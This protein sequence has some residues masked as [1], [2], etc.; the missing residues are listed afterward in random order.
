MTKFDTGWTV[1]GG[2]DGMSSALLAGRLQQALDFLTNY[3]RVPV[4]SGR[5]REAL[6]V[7]KS[8]FEKMET[9]RVL[10]AFRLAWETFL[11]VVAAME[12]AKNPRTPFTRERLEKLV[13]GP[14][15]DEGRDGGPRNIQFE[16]LVASHFRLAGC[17]VYD[18]EPDIVLL[19]GQEKVG[20]AVKRV[21]SLKP[22][23]LLRHAKKAADQV[24]RSN[25][26]GWIVLNVDSRVDNIDYNE[27]DHETAI[28]NFSDAFD[29][30]SEDL[31]TAETRGYVLGHMMSGYVDRWKPAS[32]ACAAELHFATPFRWKCIARNDVDEQLFNTFSRSWAE[33]FDRRMKVVRDPRF[34]G[35]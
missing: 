7:L 16:L 24:H 29:V 6:S 18:G 26:R 27:S 11:I 15:V 34:T 9:D 20:L 19:Y 30:V 17:S 25:M 33:R 12:D 10:A 1:D 28:A 5:H 21:R 13:K 35:L 31:R 3:L 8:S 2:M 22:A 4:G 32:E 14:L 23:Q